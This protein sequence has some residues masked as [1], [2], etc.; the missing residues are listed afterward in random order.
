VIGITSFGITLIKLIIRLLFG[1]VFM[2]LGL[3]MWLF[4][5]DILTGL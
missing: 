4:G 5:F 3:I 2:P 1:Y